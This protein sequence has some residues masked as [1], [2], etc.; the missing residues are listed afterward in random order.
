MDTDKIGSDAAR[1]ARDKSA[2]TGYKIAEHC[3]LICKNCKTN[4]TKK[5]G[6]YPGHV[7]NDGRARCDQQQGGGCSQYGA[8]WKEIAGYHSHPNMNGASHYDRQITDTRNRPEY[9]ADPAN[10]NVTRL[11]P[12][13]NYDS[14]KDWSDG[15]YSG[16]GNGGNG[17][18]AL[19]NPNGNVLMYAP[20]VPAP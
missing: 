4:E 11:D 15:Q 5:T 12:D 6:P 9:I 16:K 1:E 18:R 8:D 20:P 19:I 17:G 14:K 10:D 13:P 2:K 7:D 3:G